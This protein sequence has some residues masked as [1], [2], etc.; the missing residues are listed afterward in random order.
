MK[1]FFHSGTSRCGKRVLLI[2]GA[3]LSALTIFAAT[4]NEGRRNT[5]LPPL[6]ESAQQKKSTV[7]G[8]LTDGD[9][10]PIIGA[11]VGVKG[12]THGVTTDIDGRYTL[13]DVANGDIIE[14]RYIG[15]VT[16][17]RTYK[18][19]P[20]INIRMMEAFVSLDDVVVIGYGQQKKESLVI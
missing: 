6:P 16:E 14:F 9:G 11:T 18:G 19:E 8:L 4:E 10:N 7:T 15:M 5:L 2:S 13:N 12:T 17:E 3:M 20:T 1:Y